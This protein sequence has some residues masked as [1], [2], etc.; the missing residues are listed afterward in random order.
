MTNM[1][2]SIPQQEI[3]RRRDMRDVF[4]FTIDP[5]DAKDFDDA[6]SFVE[7]KEDRDHE[8]TGSRDHEKI[9]RIGVHIADVSYYVKPGSKEDEDAYRRG[10]SVYL[11]DRVLPMLPERLCNNLCSLRPGEDKL[12]MSVIFTMDAD[13]RVL[14]H[15]ICRTV[16]CSDENETKT[17]RK[18]VENE[19]KTNRTEKQRIT[20]K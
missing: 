10:T 9:F 18:R 20:A 15:K 6:L 1:I 13:A 3:L 12:C 4:T 19:T 14:K 7:V 8:I 17:R 16:I 11:V 2:H 5:A